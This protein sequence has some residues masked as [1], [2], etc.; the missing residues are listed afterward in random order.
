M[1][2]FSVIIPVYNVEKYIHKC[3]E[4]IKAQ[5]EK[6]FEV[7]MVDDGSTDSCSQICD[8]LVQ[9]GSRF[10]VIHKENG[11]LMSAWMRGLE[12]AK[13][14]YI[15]FVDSDDWLAPRAFERMWDI[16][17]KYDVDMVVCNFR[18]IAQGREQRTALEIPQG[19]YEGDKLEREVYPRMLN[20]G[21]FQ[22]RG[23][24][25]SR[26]GKIIRKSILMDNLRYCDP[27][28]SYQEDLNIILPVLLDVKRLYIL[29][30][31]DAD[32]MYR[33]NPFSILHSYN[34]AMYEQS[35]LVYDALFRC[36][37]DK[38]AEFMEKQLYADSLAAI[39][40]CYKN[41]LLS[42]TYRDCI[43]HIGILSRD[44]RFEKAV[45]MTQWQKYRFLNRLIIRCLMHWN[46]TNR[47][48]TTR[49]MYGMK[50]IRVAK[51]RAREKYYR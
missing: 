36:I 28:V 3:V 10:K 7:I 4:S 39:V 46:F 16:V 23:I 25:V 38:N 44:K 12:E 42:A 6:D 15:V 8:Y 41:D 1:S 48:V 24:P 17:R 19:L 43:D 5:T 45:R 32:Y 11:G 21:D 31:P 40:Q 35:V 18:Q 27:R 26:W 47:N 20:D 50:R 14:E 30:E 29:D 37:Q 34:P 51:V 9:S 2:K 33:L 22:K 13:T 49:A